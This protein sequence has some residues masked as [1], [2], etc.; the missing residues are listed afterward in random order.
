MTIIPC[1]VC[2]GTRRYTDRETLPSMRVIETAKQCT[3]C[4]GSGE[5]DL[6][7]DKYESGEYHAQRAGARKWAD[8]RPDKWTADEDALVLDPDI[9]TNEAL[10]RLT[11]SGYTRTYN[12]VASR[13]KQKCCTMRN[14]KPQKEAE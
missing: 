5:M 3:A 12:A 10:R 8:D 13:R 2:N 1:P 7:A 6:D 4:R 11:E 14:R 9:G